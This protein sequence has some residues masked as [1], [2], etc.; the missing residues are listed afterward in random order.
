M[1]TELSDQVAAA[2]NEGQ[3]SEAVGLVV[4][5]W[6][7]KSEFGLRH[8]PEPDH[9]GVWVR[10]YT[11]GYPFSM[12]KK[13]DAA[14]TASETL[15]LVLP[16][17]ADWNVTDLNGKPVVLPANGDRPVELVDN[18]EDSLLMW[19]IRDFTAFWWTE[20]LLPRKNS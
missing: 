16:H 19:L 5:A 20:L 13:W 7:A 1:G 3:Y 15:E 8:C 18:V 12:R 9:S 17:I 4:R 6:N 2:V 11:T 14:K 10:F